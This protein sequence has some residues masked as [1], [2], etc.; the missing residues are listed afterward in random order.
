MH[1]GGGGGETVFLNAWL[2]RE[3]QQRAAGVDEVELDALRIYDRVND[4]REL[5]NF[6]GEFTKN[7]EFAVLPV[8]IF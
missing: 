3:R 2:L 4:G 6:P 7:S 1:E 8:Q 5:E